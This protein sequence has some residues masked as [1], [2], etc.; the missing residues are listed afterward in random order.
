M[1]TDIDADEMLHHTVLAHIAMLIGG[2]D[3]CRR[4]SRAVDRKQCLAANVRTQKAHTYYKR[5]D[6]QHPSVWTRR[7]RV[8]PSAFCVCVCY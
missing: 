8:H 7:V 5:T 3:G 4:C 6:R 2:G 1:R